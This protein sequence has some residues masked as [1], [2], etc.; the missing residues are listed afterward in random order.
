MQPRS[1]LAAIFVAGALVSASL[2]HSAPA[3]TRITIIDYAFEPA[4]QAITTGDSITWQND[5]QEPHNVVDAG[6]AWESPALDSGKTYTFLFTTPGIY[7]Y[8]CTIHSDMSGTITVT[9]L[10][11]PQTKVYI[12]TIQR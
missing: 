1:L 6:G 7:T 11:Q 9:G 8:Y 10:P 3:S 2:A 5:G 4:E 12:A